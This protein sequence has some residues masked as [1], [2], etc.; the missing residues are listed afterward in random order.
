MKIALDLDGVL[1]DLHRAV[2]EH[3][4]YTVEDFEQFGEWDDFDRFWATAGTV[5]DEHYREIDPINPH[6]AQ[7]VSFI[8]RN[9]TV[10]IVTNTAG[11]DEA[12]QVWLDDHDV[13][14]NAFVRPP[15]DEYK[16]ALDYDLFI[17][18]NPYLAGDV[19]LLYLRDRQ[20]NQS[21]RGSGEYFYHSYEDSYIESEGFPS[22]HIGTD[23][24]WVV[25][26][27]GLAA[28]GLDLIIDEVRNES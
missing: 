3:S 16:D 17:D 23:D 19:S 14:Y 12:A 1:A 24:P 15:A 22:G 26:V 11:S 4:H 27:P 18:D 21:V 7:D 2:V 20:W 25:R 10:D 13:P 5:W 8:G 6:I 9:H 28:V